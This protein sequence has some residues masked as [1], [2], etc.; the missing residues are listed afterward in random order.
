MHSEGGQSIRLLHAVII[1]PHCS[2]TLFISVCT[3]KRTK[4]ELIS[5][6]IDTWEDKFQ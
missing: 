2:A 3:Q 5:I 1:I 4:Q 6:V